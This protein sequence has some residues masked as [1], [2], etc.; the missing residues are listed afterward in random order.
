MTR[1]PVRLQHA[2]RFPAVRGFS[3]IELLVAMAVFMTVS[4][5]A[6]TLFSRHQALLGK[7]QGLAG[8]N[9]G[10]RNALTQIQIDAINAGNGVTQ[11]LGPYVPAWPVGIT[12]LNQ[13]PT[14]ACNNPA[15][16]S[17]T[18]TCFDTMNVIVADQ[19]TPAW[20]PEGSLSGGSVNT[21]STT[22]LYAVPTP[23]GGYTASQYYQSFK[24]GDTLLLV[25]GS[26]TSYTTVTLA[27]NGTL[28]SDSTA[29]VINFTS[30]SG[31]VNPADANVSNGGLLIT[32]N[33]DPTSLS[34]SYSTSDW[35]VRLSPIIY[36]V[37]TS[38]P[39]DPKL[40]R[41]VAGGN[42]DV[43]MEQVVSFKVG[44]AVFG[45]TT[46]NY[47]YKASSAS[48]N[49]YGNDFTK[50]RSVRVSMIGRTKPNPVD[51]YRNPFD[52]GPYQVLGGSIVVDPRNLSM[53]DQ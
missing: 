44:A 51:T 34:A 15:T 47:Y 52:Q 3:L 38:D 1:N 43:V 40:M 14:T 16:F 41:Q 19:Q 25:S 21:D 9:I 39:T 17:Y 22:T 5:A 28:S 4:A 37:D 50:V 29:V 6:F 30:T 45:D 32:T 24:T 48:P 8:L 31:G 10:L 49:G 12:I 35:L 7:Q 13:T 46:D 36:S 26:G 2:L 53:G 33:A 18:S 11:V 27:S 20:R 23:G 42:R